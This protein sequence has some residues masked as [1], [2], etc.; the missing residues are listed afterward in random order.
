MVEYF[1]DFRHFRHEFSELR[2]L[3]TL[4][5]VPA[6]T[7][8]PEEPDGSILQRNNSSIMICAC[9]FCGVGAAS[10]VLL[11][12]QT[13]SSK[14]NRILAG[15]HTTFTHDSLKIAPDE[16]KPVSCL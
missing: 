16:G 3:E 4:P 10:T 6:A 2:D 11:L 8:T 13:Q 15:G 12:P 9:L 14:A 7:L 5:L 1:G